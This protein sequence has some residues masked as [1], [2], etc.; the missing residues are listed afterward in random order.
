MDLFGDTAAHAGEVLD[1]PGAELLFFRETRFDVTADDL[2]STLHDELA[3]REEDIVLFG[4][5]YRQPRLLAW[6]GDADASYRYSGRRYEPQPW[7]P[8]LTTLR[9]RIEALAGGR[10][11][12]VLANLYRDENDSMG[13]HADDEPELGRH[14][15]IASLSL[16]EERVFRLR[17][18]TRRDISPVRIALPSGSLLVMRGATQE[19]WKHEVPKS[20]V[21]C[22]PRINLT[23]RL[24]QT[25]PRGA[26]RR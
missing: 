17:H 1:L 25:I 13:Q 7:H 9:P 21:P 26:G 20:R 6:Y 12:S 8:A 2:F 18:R 4:R 19:N 23:F 16:G 22:G 24:V 10:F 15:V 11:N 3:W 5:R 14:P